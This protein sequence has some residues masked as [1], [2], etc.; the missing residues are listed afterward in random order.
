MTAA[1]PRSPARL[2]RR[3]GL[4]EPS[5]A[6]WA[7]VRRQGLPDTASCCLQ[8]PPDALQPP[9]TAPPGLVSSDKVKKEIPSHSTHPPAGVS[10]VQRKKEIPIHSPI[11]TCTWENKWRRKFCFYNVGSHWNEDATDPKVCHY[12]DLVMQRTGKYVPQ[13]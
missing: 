2:A 4:R 1:P 10:S 12:A 9:L 5:A 13:S 6:S 3:A 11:T 8:T 7:S